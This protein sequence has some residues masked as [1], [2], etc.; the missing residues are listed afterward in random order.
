MDTKIKIIL[1]N[2]MK[3]S[4]ETLRKI[5]DLCVKYPEL[6]NGF[7][8]NFAACYNKLAIVEYVF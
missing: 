3:E 4:S 8:F 2:R 1:Y 5:D 7:N 6:V